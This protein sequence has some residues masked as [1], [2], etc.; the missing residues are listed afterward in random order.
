[1]HELLAIAVQQPGRQEQPWEL[2][3]WLAPAA[4]GST[5]SF[6]WQVRIRVR[7]RV[8]VRVRVRV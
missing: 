2:C 8:G 7:V 6:S 3:L 5:P 4:D 1:M